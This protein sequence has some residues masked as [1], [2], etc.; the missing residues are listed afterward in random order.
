MDKEIDLTQASTSCSIS[1]SATRTST[2]SSISNQQPEA[3]RQKIKNKAEAW[4]KNFQDYVG[5]SSGKQDTPPAS[6]RSRT[7][8]KRSKAYEYFKL[9]EVDETR[10]LCNE[11]GVSVNYTNKNTTAM[12][13][14]MGKCQN[15][16]LKEKEKSRKKIGGGISRFL[17]SQSSTQARGQHAFGVKGSS[18]ANDADK[19]V[20][21]A[22][23]KAVVILKQ[24]FGFWSKPCIVDVVRALH[25]EHKPVGRQRFKK[26]IMNDY[27]KAKK[28]IAVDLMKQVKSG[29]FSITCDNWSSTCYK[30]YMMLTLHWITESFQMKRLGLS[31]DRHR[32]KHDG[33]ANCN[34]IMATL[35]EFGIQHNVVSIT[36]DN[37]SDMLSAGNRLHSILLQEEEKATSEGKVPIV[38]VL[39]LD[40]FHFR[41]MAHVNNLIT[42][43][44]L[45]HLKN[46]LYRARRFRLY[47]NGTAR[48]GLWEAAVE[49]CGF[50]GKDDA[51]LPS[52]DVATRWDSMFLFLQ[53]LVKKK[54]IILEVQEKMPADREFTMVKLNESE[55]HVMSFIADMLKPSYLVTTRASISTQVTVCYRRKMFQALSKSLREIKQKC[56]DPPYEVAEHFGDEFLKVLEDLATGIESA[57]REKV[58][59]YQN[60]FVD[61]KVVLLT[62]ILSKKVYKNIEV[63]TGSSTWQKHKAVLM[64]FIAT[65]HNKEV[66]KRQ[67]KKRVQPMVVER[68]LDD[69]SDE[70]DDETIHALD[71]EDSK[72]VEAFLAE[73]RLPKGYSTLDFWREKRFTYPL[74]AVLARR[75]LCIQTSSV[76]SER[77]FSHAKKTFVGKEALKDETFK[78][79]MDL[80]EYYFYLDPELCRSLKQM[81]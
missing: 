41:C 20:Y 77:S 63:V 79:L 47:F 26:D 21:E 2:A 27:K 54:D 31:F 25:P 68:S 4:K 71:M 16:I 11:C 24:S 34:L 65:V 28:L 33:G 61:S 29:S 23:R 70:D 58:A 69:F 1:V 52:I 53:A 45:K 59:A 46:Q 76:D 30:G 60:L 37:G 36:T 6:K 81:E 15:I 8:V 19:A 55:F 39:K 67:V 72:R 78:T 9:D 42:K 35:K 57:L 17:L 64:E 43:E 5:R 44:V 10:M 22:Q 80:R 32:G 75:Y 12:L 40:D 50:K 14:H 13:N 74:L 56:S 48:Q 62:E 38:P 51:K 3:K 49:A 66:L 18:S 73:K 7:K